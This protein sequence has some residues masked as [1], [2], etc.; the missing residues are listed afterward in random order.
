MKYCERCGQVFDDAANNVEFCPYCGGRVIA[1]AARVSMQSPGAR[2][3]LV[4]AQML[5]KPKASNKRPLLMAVL[6]FLAVAGLLV[7]GFF[8][9]QLFL[10]KRAADKATFNLQDELDNTFIG[11]VTDGELWVRDFSKDEPIQITDGMEGADGKYYQP[12]VSEDMKTI[13][14]L[15]KYDSET[16]SYTL[17]YRS[18]KDGEAEPTKIDGDVSWFTLNKKG[19]LVTYKQSDGDLYRYD[20]SEKSRIASEVVDFILSSDGETVLFVNDNGL[21]VQKRGEEKKKLDEDGVSLYDVD[22]AFS[23]VYYGAVAENEKSE[24]LCAISL[25]GENKTDIDTDIETLVSQPKDGCFYYVTDEG[26]KESFYAHFITDDTLKADAE[27]LKSVYYKKGP[28]KAKYK[29][30]AQ[31]TAAY[32]KWKTYCATVNSRQKLRTALKNA[33][34]DFE[35]TTLWYYNGEKSVKLLENVYRYEM[36]TCDGVDVIE[37]TQYAGRGQKIKLTTFLK[38]L[39]EKKITNYAGKDA[40]AL[41]DKNVQSN[42]LSIVSNGAVDTVEVELEKG[43]SLSLNLL[44]NNLEPDRLAYMVISCVQ[45]QE[46]EDESASFSV[47]DVYTI[48]LKD[49]IG[50]PQLMAEDAREDFTQLRDGKLVCIADVNKKG[51]GDLCVDGKVIGSD[52]VSFWTYKDRLLFVTDDAVL[53]DYKDGK[54]VRIDDEVMYPYYPNV[55]GSSVYTYDY[56]ESRGTG[57]LRY[58]TKKGKIITLEEDITEMIPLLVGGDEG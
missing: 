19:D 30:A 52:A 5:G 49:G 41:L 39:Q 26:V 22:E 9:V 15:D 4:N 35:N 20:M 42:V 31:Y 10:D 7:A 53:K 16:N 12:Y 11:Y 46:D 8:G 24:Q 2:G 27:A 1:A 38:T 33:T 37:A 51:S 44:H 3:G 14:Y 56:D 34:A 54:A 58:C 57:E 28:N 48:S 40:L 17:Y 50:E 36:I 29:T 43:E 13:F 47:G 18:L 45:K 55:D 32:N 23:T 21:Y 25:S 6:I